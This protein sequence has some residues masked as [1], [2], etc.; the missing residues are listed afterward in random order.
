MTSESLRGSDLRF[1]IKLRDFMRSAATPFLTGFILQIGL[2]VTPVGYRTDFL[3]N[4]RDLLALNPLTGV[5][6]GIRWC[7]L[8]GRTEL[9]LPGLAVSVA[10]G[11]LLLVTGLWYFRKTERRFADIV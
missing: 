1:A 10:S 8:A 7:L 6:D 5:I 11:A 4:W 9:H 2:F 3:P